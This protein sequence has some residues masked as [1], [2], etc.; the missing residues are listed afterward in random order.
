MFE[1]NR[2]YLREFA[3]DDAED[4]FQLN[5][6]PEVIRYTGD[7][8]FTSVEASR[9]F[10]QH[11]D[12]YKRHGFGRWAVIHKANNVFIGWCGLKYTEEKKEYDVGF[13]FFKRYWNQGYATESAKFCID[14]GFNEFKINSIVGRAMKQNLASIRVLEKVGLTFY[15]TFDF[16]GHEG[17]MYK[18]DNCQGP[19]KVG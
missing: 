6:D 10:L 5:L 19:V 18:I 4:L 14:I 1:T 12:S 11:Y 9:L 15:K 3:T 16:N 7:I 17:V 8:P 13:R 2:L